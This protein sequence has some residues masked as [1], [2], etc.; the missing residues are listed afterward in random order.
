MI[1]ITKH[2]SVKNYTVTIKVF[3]YKKYIFSA[4][5]DI[6]AEDKEDAK[7]IAR[8]LTDS[9]YWAADITVYADLRTLKEVKTK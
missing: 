9:T 6:E 4:E 1:Y 8:S 5:V 7:T 2:K 3:K